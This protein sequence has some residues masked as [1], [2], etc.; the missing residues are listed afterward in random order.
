MIDLYFILIMFV[1][2][3]WIW[4]FEHLF[5]EGEIFEKAGKWIEAKVGDWWCKP[6]ICC[7]YCMSSFHGTI[8]YW[9]LIPEYGVI[10]WPVFCV[11]LCGLTA[12][13]DNK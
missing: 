1:T 7:K 2:V 6:L 10:L 5:K 12:I 3:C 4:G 11:C 8:F 9:L 13:L